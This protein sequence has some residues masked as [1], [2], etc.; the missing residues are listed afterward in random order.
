MACP[1]PESRGLVRYIAAGMARQARA[2][3]GVASHGRQGAARYAEARR[4][5]AGQVTQTGVE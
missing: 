4:G 3:Q 5:R 2:G 1:G